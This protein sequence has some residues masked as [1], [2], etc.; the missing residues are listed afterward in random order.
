MRKN[1]TYKKDGST[2]AKGGK[3]KEEYVFE[4]NVYDGENKEGGGLHKTKGRNRQH[5]Y[6][7]AVRELEEIEGEGRVEVSKHRFP[8]FAKGGEVETKREFIEVVNQVKEENEAFPNDMVNVM[9]SINAILQDRGYDEFDEYTYDVRQEILDR[10]EKKVLEKQGLRFAKGG[11][12]KRR[13]EYA[14]VYKIY[15]KDGYED[16]DRRD[17]VYPSGYTNEDD[18]RKEAL[19]QIRRLNSIEKGEEIELEL[20]T[21]WDEE[22][23]HVLFY[24]GED[25]DIEEKRA[26]LVDTAELSDG[27]TYYDED[28]GGHVSYAKGGEVKKKGNEM[29]MGGLAG[30]LFGAFLGSR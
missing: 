15:D 10:Y 8:H 11:E 28:K 2:F 6:N 12:V 19:K 29:V 22:T 7:R 3:T 26:F 27:P 9:D 4:Y 14:F 24:N 17:D 5:A 1:F 20:S 18:A 25:Y 16:P 30:I 21:I 23:G 13:K